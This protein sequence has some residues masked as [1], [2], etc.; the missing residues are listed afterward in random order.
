MFTKPTWPLSPQH[1]PIF[2]FK[3]R[4]FPIIPAQFSRGPGSAPALT[5]GC[6]SC[7]SSSPAQGEQRCTPTHL[8]STQCSVHWHYGATGSRSHTGKLDHRLRQKVL[9]ISSPQSNPQKRKASFIETA[10]IYESPLCAMLYNSYI[11]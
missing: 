3:M 7:G 4:I 8:R 1:L 11:V 5:S 6:S 9:S 10:V 2:A